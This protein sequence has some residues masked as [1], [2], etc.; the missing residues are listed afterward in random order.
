MYI[1]TYIHDTECVFV[2][3]QGGDQVELIPAGADVEVTASNIHDYVRK[4]AEYRMLYVA[5][6][7]LEV[8]LSVGVLRC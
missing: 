5:E 4:Y 6:K 7:A 2:A 3:W 8:S 1:Y